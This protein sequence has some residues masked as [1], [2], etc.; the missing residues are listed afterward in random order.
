MSKRSD[1]C[2]GKKCPFWKRYQEFCPNFVEGEWE[3]SE[4]H[5]YKTKDCAPKR[6]MILSQ[7][8]YDFILG[9]RKDLNEMRNEN[10]KLLEEVI[11]PQAQIIDIDPQ[12]T[13]LIEG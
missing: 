11:N 7:Q 6:S 2:H 10:I 8:V 5:V 12:T 9:T 1:T 3:T 13:K 4:G